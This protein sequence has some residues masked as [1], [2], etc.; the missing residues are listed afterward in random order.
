MNKRGSGILLHITS[1]P[2]PFGIGDLGPWAYRFVDF[3]ARSRQSFWQILPLNPTDLLSGNNPYSS[4]SA[5]AGNTLLI[6]PELM[7][8]EGFLTKDEIETIPHFPQEVV[9]Y[10]KV[11]EY[12]TRLFSRAFERFKKRKNKDYRGFCARNSYWLNDFTLFL[13]IKEYFKG[14]VWKEWPVPVR[15]RKIPVLRKLKQEL[16]DK[17][18]QEKFLQY[19]FSRQWSALKSYGNRKGIRIVGDI[20]IYVNYDSADVWANPE[21]FKLDQKRRPV[22]V[23]GVPPDYFSATGQLWGNPIYRWKKIKETGYSWWVQRIRHNLKLFDISRIDHFRGLVA[24]WEVRA[25]EKTAIN[26]KWIRGPGKDFFKAL[27][28]EMPSLP[29]IAEDLGII[30]QEVRD[31][32]AYFGFP[33]MKVLLFAFG[34]DDPRH[35]Y[36]PHNHE[37]N[38]VV[39]TGTHDNNTVRGWFEDEASE[40]EKRRVFRYLDRELSVNEIHWEFVKLAHGSPANTAI[41]PMQDILGLGKEARMN[42]PATV[43]GNYLWRLIPEQLT[44]SL[45]ERLSEITEFYSRG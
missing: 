20:A 16:R 2:S 40:D 12:K 45:A 25:G 37:A 19:V 11:S 23:S 24:Y 22:V 13:A 8:R 31:T 5:F 42:I 41:I 3:L 33:G 15:E 29:I 9:D 1:L 27:L 39:Y 18:E 43:R 14:Q 26:G 36:L 32:M 10:D 4:P 35:P 6:S 34:N 17:I 38:C 7:S 44:P 21:I 30:T 28:E